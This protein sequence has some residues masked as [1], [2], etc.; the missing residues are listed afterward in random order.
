MP[1]NKPSQRKPKSE[2]NSQQQQPLLSGRF[3]VIAV[4]ILAIVAVFLAYYF[5]RSSLPW[6]QGGC[7][8]EARLCPDGSAVG[9]RGP[10]CEFTP[11][12][13]E[14]G[15]KIANP[16]SAY[17]KTLGGGVTII[18]EEL[19]PDG[20]GE[21]GMCGFPDGTSCEEWTVYRGECGGKP[22][23]PEFSGSG[24]SPPGGAGET[25]CSSDIDCVPATQCHPST[26][27]NKD[28]ARPSGMMCTMNCQPGTLDCG[29]GQCACVSGECTAIIFRD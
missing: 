16:A 3:F 13:G 28:Y 17:C 10:N 4:G 23:S 9:R 20:G 25:S 19:G 5:F 27:I 7:T 12:P 11:C 14:G 22:A 1:A 2:P 18:R 6:E 29:Q 15:S 21:V 8:L 26:C 24:G